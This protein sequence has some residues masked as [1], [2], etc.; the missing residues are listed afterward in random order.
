MRERVTQQATESS[1]TTPT[2]Q[3]R[4][5]IVFRDPVVAAIPALVIPLPVVRSMK[6]S[7]PGVQAGPALTQRYLIAHLDRAHIES[8]LLPALSSANPRGSR[9]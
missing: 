1:T 9:L 4:T 7:G 2:G 5:L 3:L 6:D 8:T